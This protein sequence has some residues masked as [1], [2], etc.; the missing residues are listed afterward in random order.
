M[1]MSFSCRKTVS[2]HV[3]VSVI[4]PVYNESPEY[5]MSAI[6]SV[7]HQ[8]DFVDEFIICDDGAG[9]D[10]IRRENSSAVQQR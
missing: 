8:K 10:K 1:N 6:Q 3:D 9:E 4:M 5:V 2:E 7:L